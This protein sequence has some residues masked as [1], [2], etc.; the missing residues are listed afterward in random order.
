MITEL[1]ILQTKLL[2]DQKAAD[3]Y[4]RFPWFS[5]A[6]SFGIFRAVA[7]ETPGCSK[8][9]P[10]FVSGSAQALIRRGLLETRDVPLYPAP[11]WSSDLV[12][13]EVAHLKAPT[14]VPTKAGLLMCDLL[15]ESGIVNPLPLGELSV[16]LHPE[17]RP[18]IRIPLEGEATT[19]TP[20]DRRYNLM[21]PGDEQFFGRT[22]QLR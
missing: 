10:Q 3:L 9:V 4:S 18:K 11:G 12:A 6:T 14:W 20:P 17:D 8:Y 16:P 1:H 22:T 2:T 21:Q 13:E 7:T 19:E 5:F 15:E